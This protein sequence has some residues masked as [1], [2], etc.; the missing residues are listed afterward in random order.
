[1]GE[2]VFTAYPLGANIVMKPYTS[3]NMIESTVDIL[4][5]NPSSRVTIKCGT[6]EGLHAES[7]GER[8]NFTYKT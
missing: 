3:N 2:L 7:T 4:M 1:M 5:S 8:R 6:Q